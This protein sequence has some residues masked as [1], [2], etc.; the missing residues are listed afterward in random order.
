[1]NFDQK[2]HLHRQ[3]DIGGSLRVRLRALCRAA[4]ECL[5]DISLTS[6]IIEISSA[7]FLPPKLEVLNGGSADFSLRKSDPLREERAR[8]SSSE[9]N[10][11][12]RPDLGHEVVMS[13][14]SIHQS[15]SHHKDDKI[16]DLPSE[17]EGEGVW[18]WA[19]E[20]QASGIGG[21]FLVPMG[22][23]LDAPLVSQSSPSQMRHVKV[24]YYDFT[25][26][27]MNG[28]KLCYPPHR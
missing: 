6:V 7:F 1:M 27:H 22:E 17:D 10:I 28:C 4:K 12:N 18:H 19:V 15:V 2:Y 24:G 14:R 3:T 20:R 11:T 26:L 25:V 5:S 16:D 8:A 23:E 21:T 13:G 9:P